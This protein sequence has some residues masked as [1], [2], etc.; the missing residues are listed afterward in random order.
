MTSTHASS[1]STQFSTATDPS[2][3]SA[4]QQL[5]PSAENP[6]ILVT[7]FMASCSDD[8]S[9]RIYR[10][11]EYLFTCGSDVATNDSECIEAS[12]NL[13]VSSRDIDFKL[14]I[15]LSTSFLP[16][17]HTLTYSCFQTKGSLLA[18]VTQHGFLLLFSLIDAPV[19]MDASE[20]QV[21]EILKRPDCCVFCRKVANGSLEG[22]SW[23]D[24][25]LC[26]SSADCCLNVK[27]VK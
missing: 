15:L 14:V 13:K 16:D 19:V 18:V 12:Q 10:V 9:I 22:L 1:D 25:K 5:T 6:T 26:A 2:N 27:I 23:F 11:Q 8:K 7:S 24:N 3:L 4:L 17:W 21:W 20:E